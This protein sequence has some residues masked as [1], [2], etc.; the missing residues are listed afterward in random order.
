M[1]RVEFAS[2]GD[3]PLDD[4][5][6]SPRNL[7]PSVKPLHPQ[8]LICRP[9]AEVQPRHPQPSAGRPDRRDEQ[10][11]RLS[12]GGRAA[13][14][15][16]ALWTRRT[17]R[18]P[19]ARRTSSILFRRHPDDQSKHDARRPS[20][21]VFRPPSR[22]AGL[23]LRSHWTA[24]SGPAAR[25]RPLICIPINSFIKSDAATSEKEYGPGPDLGKLPA[26]CK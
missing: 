22:P 19:E 24:A 11:P 1:G 6:P 17:E 23:A 25:I 8:R 9:A 18:R 26:T 4:V 15:P 7:M 14:R 21:R 12:G 5:A 16:R 20:D 10:L 3:A 2:S 13:A